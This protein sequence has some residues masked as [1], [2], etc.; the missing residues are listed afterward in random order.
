MSKLV[1]VQALRGLA[2]L[3]VAALH[4]Q[5]DAQA[6][7][8]GAGLPFAAALHLPWAAGVDVFF[9][10]SGFIMVYAS[11]ELFAQ[12]GARRTF[13]GRR[14]ARIV[15]IYWA[16]TLAYLS[17]AL[18]APAFVNAPDLSR[19]AILS[20]FLFIPRLAP[21]GFAHPVFS[22]GWTLNYEMA[23]YALFALA[24]AFA[25]RIAVPAL[26]AALAAL[27]VV[28]LQR[29]WPEPLAFWTKPIVL[30]FAFGLAI[31]L[32]A[33]GVALG[34]WPRAALAAAGLASSPCPR[35]V[36]TRSTSLARPSS[37]ACPPRSSSPPPPW[38]ASGPRPDSCRARRRGVGDASYALYLV[39]PFAIRG[40]AALVRRLDLAP[41]LAGWTSSRWRS[42]ARSRRR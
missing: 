10:I 5:A 41:T 3:S 7:A 32:R 1:L 25:R 36:P 8:A 15:P 39:H 31:G 2:A 4:A 29:T 16:V 18:F 26:I 12:P 28:G 34:P 19:A 27:V 6:L 38:A 9:V 37:G 20:S 23:F 42:P 35:R 30:E 21:D 40:L 14:L 11:R 33:E 13:F 22:L 17:I 24:I